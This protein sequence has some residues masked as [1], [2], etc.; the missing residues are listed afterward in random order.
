MKQNCTCWEEIY[1][2]SCGI[3]KCWTQPS[4]S[5]ASCSSSGFLLRYLQ[6]CTSHRLLVLDTDSRHR[7]KDTDHEDEMPQKA[8]RHHLQRPRLHRGGAKQNSASHWAPRRPL[9]H[10][11]ATQTEMVRARNKIYRACQDNPAGH[12]ARREKKR[13]TEKE[14]GRQHPGMDCHDAGCR[15]E[16]G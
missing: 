5:D 12:S 11:K 2:N 8:P 6:R 1:T 3:K 4:N 7:E 9:G 14:M 16:E 10:N 13:Q 15:H